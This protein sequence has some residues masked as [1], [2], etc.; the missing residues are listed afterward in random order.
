MQVSGSIRCNV[1][2]TELHKKPV[3]SVF[4][5][6]LVAV[7]LV[8]YMLSFTAVVLFFVFYTKPAGC[9][10]NKFF[11]SFNVL[12]CIVASVVSVLHKVQVAFPRTSLR[13]LH[14]F[15]KFVSE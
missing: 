8:N 2:I 4:F 14:I 3:L 12:F 13:H 7:T 9:G 5:P 11:I 10:L 15:K 1:H 6:A